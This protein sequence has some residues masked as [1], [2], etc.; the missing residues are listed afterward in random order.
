MG[1]IHTSQSIDDSGRG[2]G[3]NAH[4]GTDGREQPISGAVEPR[5][6][7]PAGAPTAAA[8]AAAYEDF[9]AALKGAL[10]DFHRLDL[11]AQNPLLRPGIGNLGASG[12]PAELKAMLVETVSTLFTNPRDE[13][14]RRVVE[15]T[16]SNPL[17]S[18]EAVADRLSLSFG[19]YRRYLTTRASVW[20]AGCG[21]RRLRASPP[22][23]LSR[24]PQ[25]E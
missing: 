25:Q 14:L 4:D 24:H 8:S 21:R 15:L 6:A 18:Q 19:T 12:G 17:R 22:V 13:K 9:A 23:K 20:Q 16:Y 5:S 2:L 10:R 1:P 7:V 11:L 3:M